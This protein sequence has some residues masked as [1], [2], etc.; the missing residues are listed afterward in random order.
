MV[1]GSVENAS[2]LPWLTS[3][4]LLHT[5]IVSERKKKLLSWS[6]SL[7]IIITFCLSLLGTFLVRSGVLT[8]V[9]AFANDPSRGVFILC[10]L[11]FI[12]GAGGILLYK[13]LHKYSDQNNV[14][15]LSREGAISLNN[16]FML[17]ITGTVLL[18][19][20]YPLFTDAFFEKKFQWEHLFLMQQFLH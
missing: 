1:L 5:I 16:I 8:S 6:I 3:T 7:S 11:V 14:H 20:I 18:G 4:A 13:N 19:T 15:L 9:H 10:L 17:T 2:L 12:S